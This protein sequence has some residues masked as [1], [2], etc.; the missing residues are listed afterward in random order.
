M[1]HKGTVKIETERLI[2]RKIVLNDSVSLYRSG[3][4]G[5]DLEDAANIVLEMIR[6]Y[7]DDANYNWGIEYD[8]KV[9]GRIKVTEISPRDNYMQIGYDI[10][11]AYRGRGIM[12]EALKAVISFLFD[13]IGVHRIYG[14]CRVNNAASARVMQKA[15]MICEGR[16]RKHFIEE[17]GSYSDVDIYGIIKEDIKQN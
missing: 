2:L 8:K 3:C 9:I 15:G 7:G 16:Q 12:S 5:E 1:D 10:G 11:A 17:D 13:Q 4:L 14:Q 6:Y